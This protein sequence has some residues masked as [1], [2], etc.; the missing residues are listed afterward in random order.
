LDIPN[1]VSK[2]LEEAVIPSVKSIVDVVNRASGR[3]A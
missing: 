1:P 3:S 2:K